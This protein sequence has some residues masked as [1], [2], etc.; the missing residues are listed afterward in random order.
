MAIRTELWVRLENTPG[1]MADV[2]EQLGRE[3]VHIVALS[4]QPGIGARLL[5]DNS[6]AAAAVLRDA[7]L[8]VVER[9]VLVTSVS[10]QPG[11]LGRLLRGVANAGVNVEYA[12]GSSLEGRGVVTVVL[13]VENVLDA[14]ARAGL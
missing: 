4:L 14:S 8:G 10:G 6:L 5:V 2:C 12:Y 1:A 9:D 7:G 3:H 11:S 13:G